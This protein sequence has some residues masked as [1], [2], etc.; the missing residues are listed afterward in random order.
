MLSA[1]PAG[2]RRRPCISGCGCRADH[3]AENDH[4][5]LHIARGIFEKL[6]RP[7]P[8]PAPA[9]W[10]EPPGDTAALRHLHFQDG[11]IDPRR[12]MDHVLDA[13]SFYPFKELYGSSLVTGEASTPPLRACVPHLRISVSA[14]SR[15]KTS[16]VQDGCA[17][18]AI[19]CRALHTTAAERTAALF[20]SFPVTA[21]AVG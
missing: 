9:A 18:A 16:T 13:G 21:S 5:A 11:A 8:T 10:R 17:A 4:H 2:T 20:L 6:P 19:H 3:L 7:P 12:V 1:A 14:R 15:I